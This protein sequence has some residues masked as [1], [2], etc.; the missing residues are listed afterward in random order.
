MAKGEIKKKTNELLRTIPR[1]DR[2]TPFAEISEVEERTGW[3][4][5]REIVVT[6]QNVNKQETVKRITEVMKDQLNAVCEGGY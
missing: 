6:V 3:N 5:E 4:G 2:A 1:M